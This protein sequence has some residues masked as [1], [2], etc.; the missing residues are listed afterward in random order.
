M[1]SKPKP[2]TSESKYVEIT[3]KSKAGIMY[4]SYKL[5]KTK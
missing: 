2:N 4:V 1:Y 5:D 3:R